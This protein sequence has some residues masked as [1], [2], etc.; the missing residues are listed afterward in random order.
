[1]H[2]MLF[3]HSYIRMY[4]YLLTLCAHEGYCSCRVCMCVCVC[5]CVCMC[6][7]VHS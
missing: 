7:C 6:V 4:V 3:A 5:V 1:M 2:N